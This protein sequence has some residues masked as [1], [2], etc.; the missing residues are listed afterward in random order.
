MGRRLMNPRFD[1]ATGE[2]G[3]IARTYLLQRWLPLGNLGG[4]T[5]WRELVILIIMHRW[6]RL[7]FRVLIP[8][9]HRLTRLYLRLRRRKE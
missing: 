9:E 7:L 6:G 1:I 8:H 5:R 3:R 4:M 2:I